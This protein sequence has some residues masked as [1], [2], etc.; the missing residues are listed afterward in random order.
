MAFVANETRGGK[1]ANEIFN[2]V[3]DTVTCPVEPIREGKVLYLVRRYF[4]G[5]GPGDWGVDDTY[6]LI[7]ATLDKG[8]A[9]QAKEQAEKDIKSEAELEDKILQERLEKF[10]T[11][12][13]RRH[14]DDDPEGL[15]ADSQ[16]FLE[17]NAVSLP[18]QKIDIMEIDLD[19]TYGPN[20]EPL[21]GGG[22]YV[23]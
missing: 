4:D 5:L 22:A 23:E 12:W 2:Q 6:S 10:K 11:N 3:K 8:K 20:D 13:V 9:E 15:E 21:L 1:T 16:R 18:Y 7:L 19:K 17:R 14:G